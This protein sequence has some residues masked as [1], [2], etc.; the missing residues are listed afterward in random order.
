MALIW[1][2]KPSGG[3]AYNSTEG[4]DNI[5]CING[6]LN[7]MGYCLEAQA[8]II[9]NMIHE[10][11]LNPWRWQNDVVYEDGGYGLFQ[12]TPA[13]HYFWYCGDVPYFAGNLSTVATYPVSA[14]PYDG[15]CQLIVFDQDLLSKWEPTCWR[16]YWDRTEYSN[17]WEMRRRL[18]DTYG[19]NGELSQAQFKNVANIDWATFAFLACYEGPGKPNFSVRAASARDV[20]AYLSGETPPPPDP[21]GPG[22]GPQPP[23]PWDS[24]GKVM[25][26][27]KPWWKRGF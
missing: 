16:W 9:G 19:S 14:R 1:H 18:I 11:A 2:A 8:G 10:S 26:Y 25:F 6:V 12:F 13:K 23:L 15:H 21:P 5:D 27:L 24:T 4:L 22:P 17:L 7:S 3:Y 20:Y